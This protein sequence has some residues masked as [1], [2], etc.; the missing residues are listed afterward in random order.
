M[1]ASLYQAT[2]CHSNDHYLFI[3]SSFLPCFT[4]DFRRPWGMWL[5]FCLLLLP[6]YHWS[7][8][9]LGER[10]IGVEIIIRHWKTSIDMTTSYTSSK[11]T[12]N[13]S[14]YNE[15]CYIPM[16]RSL[17]NGWY[18]SVGQ[19]NL[20]LGFF[21][22]RPCRKSL[23]TGDIVLGHLTGSFIMRLQWYQRK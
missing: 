17:T 13:V 11:I 23:N 22:R 7:R 5:S 21:V 19:L 2:L 10:A 6:E 1:L 3:L 15:F 18:K 16:T 20:S 9:R 14:N 8:K 4:E 12:Y